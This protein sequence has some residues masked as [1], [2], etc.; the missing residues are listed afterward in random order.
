MQTQEKLTDEILNNI[1]KID[2][3]SQIEVAKNIILDV[4][5]LIEKDYISICK[6][7][8]NPKVE[9]AIN[10]LVKNENYTVHIN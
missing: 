10:F 2:L 7:F 3:S 4:G 5:G 8:I 9:D 6:K 1:F